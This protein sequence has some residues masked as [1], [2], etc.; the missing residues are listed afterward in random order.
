MSESGSIFCAI[1]REEFMD[2]ETLKKHLR[3]HITGD[4][5]PLYKDMDRLGVSDLGS[6]NCG[7]HLR[8]HITGDP[9]PLDMT[10]KHYKLSHS[11]AKSHKC[12]T[13][14]KTFSEGMNLEKHMYELILKRRLIN[15][16]FVAKR[17][18]TLAI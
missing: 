15:V 8:A 10:S 6:S 9:F 12:K 7:K 1:C 18:P 17:F 4:I 14:D 5:F 3:A 13:C 16:R 11:G 2:T